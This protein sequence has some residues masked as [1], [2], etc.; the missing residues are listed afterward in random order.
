MGTGL[1]TVLIFG[2][3]IVLLVLGLPIAFTL[4]GIAIVFILVLWGPSGLLMIASAAYAQAGSFVLVAV[5][6]FI[7]MAV[8]LEGS[9]MAEDLYEMMHKWLGAIPGGLASGTV[10]ICA[11]FAAMAGISGVATVTMGLIALPAMLKKGYD[12]KM[13]VGGIACGG[14]LGIIIP[15]SIIAVLYGSITGTSVGK[16]FMGGMIPGI[17]I[18][19]VMI[20]YI[21]V[22]CTI[23]P[24]MGPTVPKQERANWSEKMASLKGVILPLILIAVVL[25][26][27]YSGIG[28]PTEASGIGALGA[29]ICA[30]VNKK[31]SWKSLKLASVRSLN[32]TIMGIWIVI[33]ANCFAG[34]YTA[35]GASELML[36]FV[37]TLDIP[38]LAIIGLMQFVFFI[39]GM[40]MDP[41]GMLMIC[42]PVFL[43]V[44]EALHYDPIWFGILFIVNSG[45][46]YITP[47]FGFNLFYM[48][49]IVPSDMKMEEI[50]I[51]V[52]PYV[53]CQA[54]V[55]ILV[56]F[57]PEIGM[58]L[59]GKMG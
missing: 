3:L 19:V 14:A 59:P 30:A 1:L 36:S 58:W 35:G 45:M 15:P 38:P 10:I 8:V 27:I 9:G 41:I 4:S 48:R 34:I 11:I 7:F 43:P 29:V 55:L 17:L 20:I 42:A 32:V 37:N 18:A 23:N 26:T 2:M 51:S 46:A 53:A 49:A 5:P 24:T 31:L 16:L 52:Y 44:V 13:V 54:I 47:P 25:G 6:L 33:G 22:R 50:Y 39:L 56:M 57:F 28:T 12:R 21:T 40:F